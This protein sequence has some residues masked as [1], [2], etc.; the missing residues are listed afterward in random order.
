MQKLMTKGIGFSEM[1]VEGYQIQA[2]KGDS[3]G[4]SLSPISSF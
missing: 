4:P 2:R 3:E 1:R